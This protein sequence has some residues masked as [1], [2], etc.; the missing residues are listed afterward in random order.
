V[1][2]PAI[3]PMHA[4]VHCEEVGDHVTHFNSFYMRSWEDERVV[5]SLAE[6]DE[7]A[8]RENDGNASLNPPE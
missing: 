2:C 8:S 6:A 7:Q 5:E 4:Q 1:T 3:H